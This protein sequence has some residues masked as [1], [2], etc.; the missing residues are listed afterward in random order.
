MKPSK[1]RKLAKARVKAKAQVQAQSQMFGAALPLLVG[2]Y[3]K[4]AAISGLL[5][6]VFKCA[7]SK[8]KQST[9]QMFLHEAELL[10][11]MVDKAKATG[12]DLAQMLRE[13]A[14]ARRVWAMI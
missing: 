6:A 9:Q 2:I 13:E 11:Q 14:R 8:E 5:Q 12:Q 4:E 10:D 1:I 7:S 3:K